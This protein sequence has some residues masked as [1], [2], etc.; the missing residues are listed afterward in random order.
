MSW[1]NVDQLRDT[2]ARL[3]LLSE[4]E[5]DAAVIQLAPDRR[6]AEGL[7]DSLER[8]GL[9]TSYQLSRLKKG[10]TD[11]LVLGDYKLLYRNAAGS[12]ARVFRGCSLTDGRMVGLKVL[13][14]RWA[15]DSSSVAEFRREAELCQKLRH[16]NIVPI[17]D[18]GSQGE[19]HW[20]TMEFI[21]GGNLRDFIAIRGKLSSVEAT[22][23][24][25]DMAEGLEYAIKLGITHRDLKL[26]NVLLSSTGVAKLVDF[27]LA[28][29]EAAE[30]GS[31]A[32]SGDGQQRALEYA[33]L[34]KST[35]SPP[36]DPRSDLYFLGGIYYEL[37]SGSP[38]YPRTNDRA[39]RKQVTR[40]RNIRPLKSLEPNLP[41]TVTE[42]VERLMQFV[43][44]QRFQSA[45]QVVGELRRA[46]RE[47]GGDSKAAA[48]SLP[49]GAAL[50][51]TDG[52]SD[53]P[54]AGD[55]PATLPTV[56]FVE[57]RLKQQ[58]MLRQYFT[59]HGFRVL[60]LADAE[61]ALGRLRGSNHPDSLVL[62]GDSIGDGVARAYSEAVKQAQSGVVVIALL[63]EKQ[64]A[65]REGMK[66]NATSRVMLQPTTLRD[67]RKTIVKM[68]PARSE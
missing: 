38:P 31:G 32:G 16:K 49:E 13:R 59:K 53:L 42:V 40:Y 35:G 56:L 27:G 55:S 8:R 17:Y 47:L 2:L 43:P 66:D 28:G 34:E 37:L 11:G 62:V 12:F 19:Y 14:Q 25:L 44:D 51:G 5:L 64:A 54:P 50:M 15:K 1:K 6:T 46:L 67:L 33:T 7:L 20:L 10:E 9:L 26:T 48:L 52:E 36:N 18:V 58:D 60:M 22:R 45:T 23:Y 41:R 57:S 4:A 3:R 63:S 65:L 68:M 21:E 24:T 30:D 61:R 39:E 29:L